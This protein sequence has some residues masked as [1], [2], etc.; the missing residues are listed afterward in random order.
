MSDCEGRAAN[1]AAARSANRNLP[2]LVRRSPIA[3][4]PGI[5]FAHVFAVEQRAGADFELHRSG[6]AAR[7]RADDRGGAHVHPADRVDRHRELA[8]LRI[9]DQTLDQTTEADVV[10]VPGGRGS[11][12]LLEDETVPTAELIASTGRPV[13]LD[14]VAVSGSR[15]AGRTRRGMSAR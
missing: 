1:S 11:D 12:A 2:Q 9:V 4:V 10:L 3:V 15:A 14:S 7:H 6:Q 8:R 5:A 13:R